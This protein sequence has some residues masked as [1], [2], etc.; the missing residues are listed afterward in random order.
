MLSDLGLCWLCMHMTSDE[1]GPGISN[2]SCVM[3]L[4]TPCQSTLLGLSLMCP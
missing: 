4:L 3:L 1:F 2:G